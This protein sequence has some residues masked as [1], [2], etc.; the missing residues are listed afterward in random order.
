MEMDHYMSE[1][2]EVAPIQASI[3]KRKRRILILGGVSLLNVAIL[4]LL[5]TL[6]ITP[7]SH[8]TSKSNA[9]PLVGRSAPNFS[10]AVLRL[11]ASKSTLSLSNFK[12]K[13]IVLNFWAS[14]C[15][16]CNA[17]AP[18][19][20]NTWKQM[21]AQGKNV[22]VLG[23]DFQDTSKDGMNFSQSHSITYPLVMDTNGNVAI[24]YNVTSLPQT[25]FINRNGMVVSR[26][27]GQLTA[28][29]LASGL[30]TIV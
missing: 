26:E 18:L 22:V 23:I 11:D 25:I 19:L 14:W 1:A 10:L 6:L 20:E 28:S 24:K 3:H 27:V 4:A 8:S 21:Q 12:G 7:A 9:D 13:A 29:L 2:I 17:E 5:W 16:P 15:A 30:Q